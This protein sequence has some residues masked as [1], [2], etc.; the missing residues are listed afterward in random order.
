MILYTERGP[1]F[2]VLTPNA[3]FNENNGISPAYFNTIYYQENL[4]R[5]FLT[6]LC[7]SGLYLKTSTFLTLQLKGLNHISDCII[8]SICHFCKIVL[9]LKNFS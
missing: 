3:M 1:F 8:K 4:D 2:G 6:D 5:E 7:F 9:F